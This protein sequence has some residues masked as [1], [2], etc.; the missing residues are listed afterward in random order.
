M[1]HSINPVLVKELRVR[2]RGN[3]A[4]LLLT[5]F[6]GLIGLA[7]ILIYMSVASNISFGATNFDSGPTIG[8]AIFLTVMTVALMLVCFI[9]PS[10]TSGAITGERERQSLDLLVTTL[11]SAREIVTGKML[12]SLSFLLLLIAAVLP[13]ASLSFLFGGV[14]GI[15]MVIA[16]VGLVVSALLCSAIGLFWSTLMRGSLASSALAQGTML[17]WLVG[18]PFLL[19]IFGSILPFMDAVEALFGSTLANLFGGFVLCL[20]PFI[21]LGMTQNSIYNGDNPLFLTID[22]NFRGNDM[23]VPSPWIVY[24][25]IALFVA[26]LLLAISIRLLRP[27]NYATPRTRRT[28]ESE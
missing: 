2:M 22:P 27:D 21:A 24:T 11:L 7:T 8:R 13:I 26:L 19:L 28:S 15:E 17:V 5:L 1:N 10:L 12:A 14:S 9:S 18:L 4:M 3:R 25:G 23:L 6:L 16:I 20:H